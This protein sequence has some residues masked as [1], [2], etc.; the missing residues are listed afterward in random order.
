MDTDT[1][2]ATAKEAEKGCPVSNALR[3]SLEI[4]VVVTVR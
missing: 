3:G 1:F 4:E 2:I